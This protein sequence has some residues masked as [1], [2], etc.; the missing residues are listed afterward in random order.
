MSS[1]RGN[2]RARAPA[3]RAAA[4]EPDAGA[5]R[6]G[7]PGGGARHLPRGPPAARGR[8][9]HRAERSSAAPRA[10]HPAPDPELG[11]APA[12][13]GGPPMQ[14]AILVAADA[15]DALDGLLAIAEPLAR[16][17][18][19]ELI[20]ARLLVDGSD[21]ARATA[22]LAERRRGLSDRGASCRVAVYTTDQP[23]RERPLRGGPR[24]D[25][26]ARPVRRGRA[27]APRR[28]R[29]RPGRDAVRRRRARLVGDRGGGVACRGV[30]HDGAA[31]RTK[32]DPGLGRRYASRLLARASLLVQEVSASSPSRCSWKP[33]PTASSTP[34]ATRD[35]WSWGCPIAG[36]AKASASRGSPSPRV[37]RCRR[38]SSV[39]ACGRA[40][41]RRTRR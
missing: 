18:A 27:R 40:A 28:R 16:R 7:P 17:R 30:R 29:L 35:F 3:A 11:E 23:G 31:A 37:P 1:S 6:V 41:W 12:A 25:A 36:R 10:R 19:R 21:L 33:A 14:R 38:S 26:R 13:A 2:T 9:R 24:D 32:P 22:D 34:W 39:V 8:A 4:R 20:L 15:E 5:L